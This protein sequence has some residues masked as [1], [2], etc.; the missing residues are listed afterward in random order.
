MLLLCTIQHIISQISLS[1]SQRLLPVFS[2]THEG[3][4]QPPPTMILSV[5]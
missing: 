4:G 3:V 5:F 2:L 1:S